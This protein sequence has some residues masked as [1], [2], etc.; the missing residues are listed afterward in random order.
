VIP[1]PSAL[2]A[3][4][5]VSTHTAGGVFQLPKFTHVNETRLWMRNRD[6]SG[7]LGGSGP[8][9][10]RQCPELKRRL[11]PL[12]R[13]FFIAVTFKPRSLAT[14]RYR[15]DP[16]SNHLEH[17]LSLPQFAGRSGSIWRGLRG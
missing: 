1:L 2:T 17:A 6:G 8:S 9:A 16:V 12:G 7:A 14:L 3:A 10:A 15:A 4:G 11:I 5:P 13:R